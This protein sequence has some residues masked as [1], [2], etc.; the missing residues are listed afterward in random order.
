[1]VWA[2]IALVVAAA[3]MLGVGQGLRT[4]IDKGFA[5][6]DPAWLDR[7]LLIMF[8]VIALLA[9]ATW[10]RF[11]NVSWLGERVTSDLRRRVFEHLLS[12]PPSWFESGRTGDVISRL[13][14]DTTQIESVIGSSVSIALRNLLL[15]IGGL[16]MLLATSWKLTLMVLAG[17]P[18]VVVP[19]VFFGRRV[20]KL[21]RESQ[22]RVADLGAHIDE[23]IHEIRI[24]QAYGHEAD[25][26]QQFGA[27][28]ERGFATSVRRIKVRSALIV[29]VLVLVFGAISL[30]LW[31][32]GHDVLAGK[33]SAG[34]LSAFVFYAVVVA[35]SVG[36]LSEVWGEL[37]RA[38]G[39]TERLVEILA[40][41]PNISV[42]EYPVPLP[43]PPRGDV[44]FDAVDF[45]Y[46]TRPD[47]AALANLSLNVQRGETVALVG[48]SGAGKTTV[49]QLLL[50]FY[51]PA[52]GSIRIDGVELRDAHPD[53]V[54][55]SLALVPQDPVIFAMSV[56]EN[57]RY[58]KPDASVEAVREACVDAFADEF[59][60][61]LPQG[62]DTDL[63][64]RGVRLS[65]G[66]RQRIAIARAILADRPILLLDEATSALDA[67]SERVVQ[68]AL[69]RLMQGRQGRTTLV[70]AHRLATVQRADRIL[71]M[72]DGRIIETGTHAELVA[73]DGL[74]AR[75][76]RLQLTT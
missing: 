49:F 45:F 68:A 14:S 58:G 2:G 15:L 67:E 56:L 25:D 44:S 39:A 64:E 30:I 71:V 52:R 11:Y 66:Q 20:K 38:A 16:G 75:L 7:A 9:A 28:V 24:V 36:A 37:Q 74:Y 32:G 17:V 18:L 47:T 50:R 4:V 3:A 51:D 55:R 59:I 35:G 42:P 70:I 21:A 41:A 73:A 29:A 23:T 12:L 10:V 22:D 8:G 57:V 34:D 65:G 61:A 48:P 46:P 63:G 43:D 31:I 60:R 69:E 13:T 6:G 62:Y 1:M 54:R 27:R 53:A 76:A 72:E 40:T 33:L 19:I 5:A 26:R